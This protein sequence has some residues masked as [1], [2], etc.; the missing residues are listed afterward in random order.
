ML[1]VTKCAFRVAKTDEEYY[2]TV[3]ATWVDAPRKVA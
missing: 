3:T 1:S 2:P